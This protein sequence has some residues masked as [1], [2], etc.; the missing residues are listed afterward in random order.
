MSHHADKGTAALRAAVREARERLGW[1]TLKLT[2]ELGFCSVN[3]THRLLH[4]MQRWPDPEL[5]DRIVAVLRLDRNAV[6]RAAGYLKE[7]SE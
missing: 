5:F 6:L 3:Q 1:S 2:W 4:T 7:E